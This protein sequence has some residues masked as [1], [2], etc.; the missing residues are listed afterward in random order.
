MQKLPLPCKTDSCYAVN[1]IG[2][3]YLR[4]DMTRAGINFE[5]QVR[6]ETGRKR[7]AVEAVSLLLHVRPDQLQA[8][9]VQGYAEHRR[10]LMLEAR[11]WRQTCQTV[12]HKNPVQRL[13][14][15][16]IGHRN[17]VITAH[18]QNLHLSAP[19]KVE[20]APEFRGTL[21]LPQEF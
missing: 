2:S 3:V 18:E 8:F 14:G 12:V 19:V 21:L 17:V 5:R 11:I 6:H 10:H 15:M 1:T 9:K 13:P 16:D 4:I 7:A 20:S